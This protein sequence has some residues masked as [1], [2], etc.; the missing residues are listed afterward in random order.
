MADEKTCIGPCGQALP[1]DEF[2]KIGKYRQ[3]RCKAC[4]YLDSK[5]RAARDPDKARKQARDKARRARAKDPEK[6]RLR[7]W[8]RELPFKY[9][10]TREDYQRLHD[11]Q[12]GLC[13]ICQRPNIRRRLALDHNHTTNEIRGLLCDPCNSAMSRLDAIPGWAQ[14]AEAYA[15]GGTGLFVQMRRVAA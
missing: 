1:V 6:V 8:G 13:A 3:S 12:G 14:K 7:E 4:F 11:A 5:D 9:G 10:I 15:A 2:Y